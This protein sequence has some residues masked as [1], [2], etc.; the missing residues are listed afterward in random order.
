MAMVSCS[1]FSCNVCS[2]TSNHPVGPL[3]AMN[4]LLVL[5][6]RLA[7]PLQPRSPEFAP[8]D[9]PGGLRFVRALIQH[10]IGF[11]PFVGF[12]SQTKRETGKFTAWWLV[13][14]Y[15]SL[16]SQGLRP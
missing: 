13:Q 7:A 16:T 11:L 15:R 8:G 12:L 9:S 14:T 1:E 6:T 2:T 4:S 5:A 10:C 3:R